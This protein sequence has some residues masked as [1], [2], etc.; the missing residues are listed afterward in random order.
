MIFDYTN[1][2]NSVAVI[3]DGTAVLGLGNIGP[4]AA[5]PVMEGKA[6]LFNVFAGIDAYPI[7]VPQQSVREFV[8][9][10]KNL[11]GNFAGIN[12]EDIKSPECFEIEKQL[13]KTCTIPVFHDDQHGAA[14]IALAALKT[15]LQIVGKHFDDISIVINGAGAAA[16]ATAHL[17]KKAGIRSEQLTLLDRTGVIYKGRKK[18][19][20]KYKQ[21]FARPTKKRTLSDALKRTDLFIGFSAGNVLKPEMIAKMA[22]DPIVFALANPTPEIDP[23]LARESG[24]CIIATGRSDFPNQ[25]NNALGFPG[26]FRGALDTRATKI[27]H[28]MKMAAVDALVELASAP[29]PIDIRERLE[30]QY[31]DDAI[32]GI[33]KHDNPLSENMILPKPLDPRVVPSVAAAVAQ[34]A[35]D[36]GVSQVEIEDAFAYENEVGNRIRNKQE[37]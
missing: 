25:L 16:L 10:V 5:L 23:N 35:M 8:Q 18:G 26:I 3:S 14:I 9:L 21:K 29:I 11:E 34:A 1:R 4:A 12:L 30:D 28:E 6:A 24:A 36:S 32:H 27:N 13:I 37:E 19:M 17:L 33:F 7:C 2:G 15:S 22:R 31:P 20:N